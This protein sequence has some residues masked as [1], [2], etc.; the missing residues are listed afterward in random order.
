MIN[1]SNKIE[2]FEFS[3]SEKSAIKELSPIITEHSEEIV[4]KVLSLAAKNS[5][6]LKILETNNV[7]AECAKKAWIKG[8]NFIF[9][10]NPD[11]EIAEEMKKI[12]TI[13][14]EKE[15]KEDLV[16]WAIT[17]FIEETIRKLS[18]LTEMNVEKTKAITKM[19]NFV[20]LLMIS[21]YRKELEERE[22]AVLNFMG[23]SPEL[24]KRQILIGKKSIKKE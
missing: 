4:N 13:H 11:E 23:I 7:S 1:Y 24:L 9:S 15:V 5:E 10:D 12:G 20:L 2:G 3:E 18:E 16:I 17:L 14:V 21:A 22:Q 8:I 19:F 6:V